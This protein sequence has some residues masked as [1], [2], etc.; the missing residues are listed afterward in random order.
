MQIHGLAGRVVTGLPVAA[1]VLLIGTATP[2]GAQADQAD[3]ERLLKAM[4]DYMAAQ[5]AISFDYDTNLE[6]V[7]TELQ[8]LA[9]A[10]S[11]A[12]TVNRP[13]KVRATRTGGFADVELSLRR[14]DAD[15]VW[16]DREPLRPGRKS[17]EPSII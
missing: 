11:G 14:H 2:N 5:Q 12:I 9:L 15:A 6:I 10:S 17:P 3:A 4:S 7:T 13:D 1:L 16:Q 8:K